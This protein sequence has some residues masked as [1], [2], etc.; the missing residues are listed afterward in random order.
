MVQ[1]A[2]RLTSTIALKQAVPVLQRKCD[3][4]QH[5]GSGECEECK[6]KKS[7]EK[8]NRDPLL[9]RSAMRNTSPRV[10]PPIV[11]KVLRS[12]G[13]PLDSATRSFFEPRFGQD[14]SQVRMHTGAEAAESANAVSALAY[15]VG[16]SVVFGPGQ[17]APREA[18]GQAL[19]A[20]ELA[21]TVQQ[22]FGSATSS[23]PLEITAPTD[24]AEREAAMAASA[25]LEGKPMLASS[26]QNTRLARFGHAPSCNE[27]NHLK[28]FVWPGHDQA[29]KL[30]DG[31]LQ[32]T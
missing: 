1:A 12:P 15:T 21:H 29:R 30:T 2:Q 31:A 28:P 19:I 5:T 9:Q 22:D 26:S 6:K 3:C 14:F 24:F 10:A 4:G 17:Y 8:S 32:V 23:G 13:Q 18:A 27:N 25:A 7:D 11:Q 20:H 16:R